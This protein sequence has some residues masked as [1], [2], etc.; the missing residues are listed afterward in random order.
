MNIVTYK[1]KEKQIEINM[2]LVLARMNKFQQHIM[3]CKAG[4]TTWSFR[5]NDPS[6]I[7]YMQNQLN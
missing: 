5:L 6:P 2:V 7:K 3:I 4:N 1:T